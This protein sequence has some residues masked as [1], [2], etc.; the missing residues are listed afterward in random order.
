MKLGNLIDA[1]QPADGPPPQ[2]LGAFLRWCLSG[3]WMMLGVAA[4]C[5]ALA[6]GLEA[7]TAYI[8]GK[9]IDTAVASGPE[10]FFG[11]NIAIIF[12]A[13]AFFLLVRPVL[14]GLSVRRD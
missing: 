3:A 13:L 10:G 8:L 14:F 7:G 6:G 9:V 2:T 5:S 12:A 4:I 1:F 11:A